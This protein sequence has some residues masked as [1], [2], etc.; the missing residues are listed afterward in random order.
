M[1]GGHNFEK[2]VK[3]G[4]FSETFPNFKDSKIVVMHSEKFK[5]GI[6][7]QIWVSLM[8]P[9]FDFEFPVVE[10]FSKLRV[11]PSNRPL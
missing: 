11:T 6:F 2:N 3:F 8:P 5:I 1:L 7:G 10:T 9:Y 4:R